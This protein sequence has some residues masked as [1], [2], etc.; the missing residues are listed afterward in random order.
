MFEAL[1]DQLSDEWSV[2]HS[3]SVIYRDHAQG[4][5]DDEGDFVLC[6]PDRGIVC[7][8]VKGGGL[9]CQHGAF[10]RLPAGGPARAH[11]RPVRPGARP[12]LRAAAQDRRDRRLG[13]PPPVPRPRA[14]VSGHQRPQARAGARRSTTDRRRPQRPL[15]HGRGDR[16]RARLPRGIARQARRAR[17]RRRG[18][19]GDPPGADVSHRGADGDA[20]R[21]RGAPAR[22]AD[23][24]A[25]RA[26]QPLRPRPADGRHRLRGLG[27]DD[28]RDRAR[29]PAR[30]RRAHGAVRLLQQGAA[31]PSAGLIEGRR[32]GLLHVPRS[33]HPLG[34]PRRDRASEVR[35]RH[36]AGVLVRRA[37]GRARRCDRGARRAVRRHP[38]RRGAGPAAQ[39]G[40]RG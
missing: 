27:Q 8:E 22:R 28:A 25:V 3:A 21:G 38:R 35:G 17:T 39:T 40:W 9:E 36:A 16:A 18:D 37:S 5:R 1:R 19:A 11:A 31:P 29:T 33:V 4:A 12:S 24:A 2:F 20:L 23:R 32:P 34:A 13:G 6:H 14:R 30:R 10:Y 26:A 15:G 7:L